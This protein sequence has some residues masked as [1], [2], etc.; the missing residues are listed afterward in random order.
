MFF[1]KWKY[2]QAK[3]CVPPNR[4]RVECDR[5]LDHYQTDCNLDLTSEDDLIGVSPMMM[6]QA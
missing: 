2:T 6:L 3:S 4:P 5:S 1:H